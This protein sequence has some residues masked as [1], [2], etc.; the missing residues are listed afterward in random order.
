VYVRLSTP[1]SLFGCIVLIVVAAAGCGGGS[2]GTTAT[3][4]VGGPG[5]TFEAPSDRD[6]VRGLRS[7]GLGPP[8]GKG[9]E[10]ESVTRFPLVKRFRPS[11]WPKAA[12]ELDGVAD[13]LAKTLGGT[14]DSKET[15]ATAG[16]RGRRYEITYVRDGDQLRQR[17]S[18]LLHKRTE[19]QLLCRWS[20]A[21]GEP[22]AC[23]LLEQ[24]F[25]LT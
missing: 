23:A 12:G 13:Q 4:H 22:E 19:Y 15:V 10:L 1:W 3:Q 17:I 5:F 24:S 14:I 6:V 11:L 8:D 2:G 7:V 9:S 20:E 18:L 16:T 25:T 21:D